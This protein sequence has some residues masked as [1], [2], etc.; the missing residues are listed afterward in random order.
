MKKV[1]PLNLL[2]A[3]RPLARWGRVKR[4]LGLLKVDAPDV[5]GGVWRLKCEKI[6]EACQRLWPNSAARKCGEAQKASSSTPVPASSSH[7]AIPHLYI[8]TVITS[9]MSRPLT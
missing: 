6:N 8:E 7:Y 9:P 5:I 2:A 4:H 3:T 1:K